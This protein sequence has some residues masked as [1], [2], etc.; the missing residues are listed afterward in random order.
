MSIIG[1]EGLNRLNLLSFREQSLS[2]TRKA[3]ISQVMVRNLSHNIGSH[4]LSRFKNTEDIKLLININDSKNLTKK[5]NRTSLTPLISDSQYVGNLNLNLDF[6]ELDKISYFNEYLKNRM[7]FLADIATSDPSI[8]NPM[9]FIKEVMDGLDKNRILLDRISGVSDNI[10]YGFEVRKKDG[11]RRWI[12]PYEQKF[13]NDFMVSVPNDILGCQ[14]LYIII[15]NIIRNIVKHSKLKKNENKFTIHIDIED[16]KF[17]DDYYQVGIYDNLYR[18]KKEMESLIEIRNHA[19]DAPIVNRSTGRLRN[20]NLGTIEMEVCAAYLRKLP[21]NEIEDESYLLFN[22]NNKKLSLRISAPKLI[23]AHSYKHY[24]KKNSPKYSLGYRLC[25]RKPLT[26]LVIDDD[27]ELKLGTLDKDRLRQ[28]GIWILKLKDDEKYNYNNKTNYGHEFLIWLGNEEKLKL[29]LIHNNQNNLP[30]RIL[31]KADFINNN[32]YLD[33]KEPQNT[34]KNVWLLYGKKQIYNN[35]INKV[36]FRMGKK[37]SDFRGNITYKK[38]IFEFNIGNHADNWNEVKNKNDLYYDFL[39]HEHKYLSIGLLYDELLQAKYVECLLTKV[40]IIDERIQYDIVIQQKEY[41][42]GMRYKE[43]FD[44]QGIKIPS[45]F[46]ANLNLTNFGSL[47]IGGTFQN[48][49]T[50]AN[51]ISEFI[52]KN[53]KEYDFCVIHLGILEKMLPVDSPK[54]S[55]DI[56]KII[57]KIFKRDERKKIIITSG[58]GKPQNLPIDLCFVSLAILQN[59]VETLFDKFLLVKILYNSRS[60]L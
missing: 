24:I 1:L 50:E 56:N 54:T 30:K 39:C 11:V 53:I 32:F 42:T 47:N 18:A 27:N 40:M 59:I 16:Y 43:F 49:K 10:R 44:M 8:E 35:R 34:I 46:E 17:N 52:K 41:P 19:F 9:Y 48:E 23:Y 7:D 57:N 58:R 45:L 51:K 28:F 26:L 55:S 13:V 31:K 15:E 33:Y 20:E 2:E 6:N 22:Q 25:L 12:K 36:I 3:A 38:N 14:A 4:V 5:I 21:F 29:F 37:T 60:I